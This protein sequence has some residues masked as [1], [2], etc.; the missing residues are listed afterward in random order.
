MVFLNK[1]E[2]S[3]RKKKLIDFKMTTFDP[4]AML[5][6]FL[7]SKSRL[8]YFPFIYIPE[9]YIRVLCQT[10]TELFL[11]EDSVLNLAPPLTVCG[12]THGQF[13]DT[14]R[15]FDV[16][17]GL[18]DKRYLFLGD[19][20]DRGSQSVEN[21]VFLLTLKL[22]YPDKI[23]LLRGNHETEE[24]S[25]VY[26]LRDECIKRYGFGIYSLFL[27]VFESMP[28]AAIIANKIFCVH[29]GISS[30]KCDIGLLKQV[31]RPLDLNSSTVITDLLWSDPNDDIQGFQPSPRGVSY[32]FGRQEA[33]KF[34]K[35][36]NLSLI[37]R[38]HEFCPE[39]TALPFGKDGGV[40]TVFSAS[41]YCGTMNSSAVLNIDENLLLHFVMFQITQTD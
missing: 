25:T 20:V 30:E 37:I 36:N 17:G 24:I 5:Q 28:F 12:D 35:E 15:I 1:F 19:Y 26:G 10:V 14:L 8:K 29:G 16:V 3:Y 13:T 39:G 11:T 23:Y 6:V 4:N 7:G 22:V 34:L 33:Q 31:K 38:S 18:P 40:I 21:I 41:N 27:T 2:N 32:L 9:S